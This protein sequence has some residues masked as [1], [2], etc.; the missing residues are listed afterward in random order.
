MPCAQ[1]FGEMGCDERADDK[2]LFEH[3]ARAYQAFLNGDDDQT[4]YGEVRF[5]TVPLDEGC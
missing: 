5:S 3:L 4:V 2:M 1:R